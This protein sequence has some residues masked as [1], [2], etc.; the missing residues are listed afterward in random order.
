MSAH[1]LRKLAD[2]A[3]KFLGE[4]VTE[5]VITVPA[6]F[7]DAQRQATKDAARIAG[8]NVLR[9]INEPTAAALAY[10]LEKKGIETVVVFDLGAARSISLLDVGDGVVEVRSTSGGGHLGGDDFDKRVVDWMADGSSATTGSTCATTR[11]RCSG[12]TRPRRRR[13]SSCRPRR[14]TSPFG[15][16]LLAGDILDGSTITLDADCDELVVRWPAAGAETRTDEREEV[17]A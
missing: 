4:K 17:T 5:A 6:Y 7:N 3:A 1:V 11:M 16:A 13:R 9:I 15:R 14:S 12:S 8:L 2:D 10:G